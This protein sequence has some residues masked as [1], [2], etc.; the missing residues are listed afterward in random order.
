[1]AVSN[2][3]PPWRVETKSILSFACR[4]YDASPSS[5]QSASLMRTRIP[6]RLNACSVLSVSADAL[7]VWVCAALQKVVGNGEANSRWGKLAV[8]VAKPRTSW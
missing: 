4:A 6:G 2:D 8:C 7:D 5:S 3:Q 1:M